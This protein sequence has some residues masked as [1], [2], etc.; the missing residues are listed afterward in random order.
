M[1]KETHMTQPKVSWDIGTAYDLFIS[2]FALHNPNFFGI[3]PSWAAG[4]R[5]RIPV[6]D[7]KIL[8]ESLLLFNPIN[9]IFK[10]PAPKNSAAVLWT[11]SNI[12]A[13]DRL[14]TIL[15]SNQELSSSLISTIS[16]II[17]KK[18]FSKSDRE[19][20]KKSFKLLMKNRKPSQ[21][22]TDQIMYWL[23]NA[24]VFGERYLKALTTYIE[25]FFSEEEKRILPF[26]Q[27]SQSEAL[28]ISKT[29]SLIDLIETISQG[30]HY[31]EMPDVSELILVPSFW[32][33]PMLFDVK[34]NHNI[35]M[36]LFGARTT[37]AS[38]V[39]GE[40]VPETLI[41]SLKAL[42]DST[43]LR[44]LSYLTNESLTSA[45]LSRRLRLRP[46]TVAH[47]LTALRAAGLVKINIGG[48][49]NELKYASRLKAV[50][51]T[52]ESLTT[53]LESV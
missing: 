52:C 10:L 35:E 34:I 44:I 6:E 29:V 27:K 33:T 15:S 40:V 32:T 22:E 17:R 16:D 2:I 37:E 36:W 5:A 18:D 45:Q 8:E 9:W 26:L 53:F 4:V 19:L 7:R 30:V 50:K 41:R 13:K 43:R 21:K 38:L 42:S 23:S 46:P 12:P 3:R 28:K 47:H 11:L 1:M 14:K 31:T 20:V 51:K 48:V 24:E 39:P 49:G 25:V